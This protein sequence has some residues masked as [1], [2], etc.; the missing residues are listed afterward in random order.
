MS[1]YEALHLAAGAPDN[2]CHTK[3]TLCT[4]CM[5]VERSLIVEWVAAALL[6][7]LR[8]CATNFG[9]GTYRDMIF[10]VL[11]STSRQI[12]GIEPEIN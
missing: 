11:H 5:T 10:L 6:R 8:V 1:K 12:P 3:F 7:I 2:D 9:P 4:L